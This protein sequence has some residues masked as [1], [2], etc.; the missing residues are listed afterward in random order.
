MEAVGLNYF[1]IYTQINDASKKNL[2]DCLNQSFSIDE[3]MLS[4]FSC[5]VWLYINRMKNDK[6]ISAQN[7]FA[8]IT[9]KQSLIR[10]NL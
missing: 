6:V 4:R 2:R 7:L 3:V 9:G 8:Y 5:N 10:C 1:I